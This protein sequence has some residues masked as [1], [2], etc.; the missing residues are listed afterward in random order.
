MN[1]SLAFEIGAAVTVTA[2]GGIAQSL[3]VLAG[4]AKH[5]RIDMWLCFNLGFDCARGRRWD[6]ILGW[7]PGFENEPES[8]RHPNKSH[9]D[10][11][12]GVHICLPFGHWVYVN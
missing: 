6:D 2:N 4:I 9:K 1:S 8:E 3:S 11:Y 5:S 10:D 12:L 7:S